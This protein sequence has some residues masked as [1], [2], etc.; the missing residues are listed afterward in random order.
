M[1]FKNDQERI[2]IGILIK[3]LRTKR[4]YTQRQLSESSGVSVQN[5]TKIE[6]GRYNASVDILGRIAAA[7][8]AT[9]KIE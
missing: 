9:I 3:E 4:G 7:L 5:I 2:R 8:G 6:H 1:T